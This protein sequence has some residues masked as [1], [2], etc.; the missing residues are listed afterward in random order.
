MFTKCANPISPAGLTSQ[1]RVV[2]F[3]GAFFVS[4]LPY[5]PK[6]QKSV[7]MTSKG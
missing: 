6:I 4:R 7:W 5:P 2:I 1:T 3:D